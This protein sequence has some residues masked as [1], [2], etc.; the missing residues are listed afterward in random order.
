MGN[1]ITW[2]S[3]SL[4]RYRYPYAII[5]P[6]TDYVWLYLNQMEPSAVS[7]TIVENCYS[8]KDTEN[9]LKAYPLTGPLTIRGKE[10]YIEGVHIRDRYTSLGR[11]ED[12]FIIIHET[13]KDNFIKL[14]NDLSKESEQRLILP[15]PIREIPVY[16]WIHE[17]DF[18]SAKW[19]WK[20]GRSIKLGTRFIGFD[21]IISDIKTHIS[22]HM[23]NKVY[24]EEIGEYR[25]LNILLYGNP[26]VGKTTLIKNIAND[27]KIDLYVAS[28][29]ES[30]SY[31]GNNLITM[32]NPYDAWSGEDKHILMACE[33][34]DKV[35][36][37]NEQL[38]NGIDGVSTNGN[39]IRIFTCNDKSFLDNNPALAERFTYITEIGMPI[40]ASFKEKLIQLSTT[41]KIDISNE[42][43]TIDFAQFEGT[44]MRVYTQSIT[45][46]LIRKKG[47]DGPLII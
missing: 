1:I 5:I 34:F 21:S 29:T 35:K 18:M 47:T 8:S 14:R 7:Q 9:L 36:A 15:A 26:G 3:L 12:A 27:I 37:D 38:L 23:E 4:V 17:K 41:L 20:K 28:F 10:Y 16:H 43:D 31:E 19:K 42:I 24:L 25:P 32:L 2:V 45:K 39:I 11:L 30:S 46:A 13:E 22:S 33:D 44:S 6:T 40:A